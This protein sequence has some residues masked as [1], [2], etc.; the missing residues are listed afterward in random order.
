MPS[1]PPKPP[2][3]FCPKPAKHRLDRLPYNDSCQGSFFVFENKCIC[4]L[5]V[6]LVGEMGGA[7]WRTKCSWWWAIP[8]INCRVSSYKQIH[9][10]SPHSHRTGENESCE[11]TIWGGREMRARG[12]NE[13]EYIRKMGRRGAVGHDT[14]YR[15]VIGCQDGRPWHTRVSRSIHS[16]QVHMVRLCMHARL[17]P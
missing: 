11:Y 5:C 15:W 6:C 3:L 7:C 14:S 9:T 10:P 13:H 2:K 17:P 1:P 12:N 4:G 16:C 8:H